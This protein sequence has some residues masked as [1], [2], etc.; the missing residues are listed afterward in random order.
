MQVY[1]E[2]GTRN[3]SA[4][5]PDAEA[6]ALLCSQWTVGN[7][8]QGKGRDLLESHPVTLGPNPVSP[9]TPPRHPCQAS[10]H[11]SVTSNGGSL[12]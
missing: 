7:H 12:G 6:F 9:P 4:R 5:A 1:F 11:G 10:C 3:R 8:L 2:K